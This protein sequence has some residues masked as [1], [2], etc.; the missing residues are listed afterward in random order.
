MVSGGGTLV[1]DRDAT[2]RGAGSNM[3]FDDVDQRLNVYHAYNATDDVVLRLG[4]LFFDDDGWPV[5]ASP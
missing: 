1:L 5:S 4:Q 2:F 3:V